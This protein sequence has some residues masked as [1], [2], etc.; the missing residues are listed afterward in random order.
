MKPIIVN[1][2]DISTQYTEIVVQTSKTPGPIREDLV[3]AGYMGLMRAA[4]KF[5][6]SRGNTFGTYSRHWVKKYILHEIRKS[7]VVWTPAHVQKALRSISLDVPICDNTDAD[8]TMQDLLVC[9]KPTADESPEVPLL[10]ARAFKAMAEV[11]NV[12]ERSV[13]TTRFLDDGT[14]KDAADELG[15]SQERVRQLE[16]NA[17]AK[18]RNEI[19]RD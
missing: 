18:L 9:D 4:Y 19:C 8:G 11:L 17:L 3:Q 5:D 7:Y 10:A 15:L 2:I 13:I 16:V 6:P 12:K 14:R 1:G